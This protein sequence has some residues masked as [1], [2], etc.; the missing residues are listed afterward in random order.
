MKTTT[1]TAAPE[2]GRGAA[3]EIFSAVLAQLVKTTADTIETSEMPS[4][5][6]DDLERRRLGLLK[7]AAASKMP[8]P[9]F[10]SALCEFSIET[11]RKLYHQIDTLSVLYDVCCTPEPDRTKAKN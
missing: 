9:D 1:R 3:P 10:D 5:E 11:V 7:L 6:M 4:P 8:W 2:T